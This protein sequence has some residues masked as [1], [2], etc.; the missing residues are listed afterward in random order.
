MIV[1]SAYCGEKIS[2]VTSA[3]CVPRVQF[4]M[5]KLS[6]TLKDAGYEVVVSQESQIPQSR[7]LIVVGTL[8]KNPL[9]DSVIKS[10]FH[11][12]EN[13]E[14]GS[15]GFLLEFKDD[16]TVITGCDDTGTLYGCMELAGRIKK[17]GILPKNFRFTDKPLMVLRG[18]CIG[19]QK[20]Q[21]LPGRRVYEYP[22]TPENFPFFTTKNSGR[23][24]LT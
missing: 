2:I 10:G 13:N 18:S 17:D 19:M 3:D 12:F 22:Y 4:G 6:S 1:T 5:D 20:T 7:P 16:V 14:K 23:N 15:E 11:T 9:I 24:T 21:F 8:G